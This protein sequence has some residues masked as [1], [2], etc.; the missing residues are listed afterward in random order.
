MHIPASSRHFFGSGKK[1]SFTPPPS[2]HTLWISDFKG[3]RIYA[4]N[5]AGE[6]VWE[7]NMAA[8]P[9]PLRSYNV[10]V[11]YVTV[12]PNGN[13]VAADGEGMM[14]QEIDRRT[15]KLVWQYGVRQR[16]GFQKGFLHQPDKAYKIGAHEVLI[17]DG[18]NRRVIIVDQRTNEIV[19]QYGVTLKMSNKPGYL[20]G[21]T[22]AVPVVLEPWGTPLR[23]PQK[24]H[25]GILITDTL[26]KKLLLVDRQTKKIVWEFHK[27]DAR[28]L[29]HAAPTWEGTIVVE[30]RQRGE[31]FEVNR[32]GQIIRTIHKLGDGKPLHYPSDVLRLGNGN[33]LI[34]EMGRG[35]I[36][37]VNP[38]TLE[39]VWQFGLGKPRRSARTGLATTIAIDQREIKKEAP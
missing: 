19:W 30:D 3:N 7:Q 27:P 17:N 23:D 5:R 2:F 25:Y 34:A 33:Y 24:Q 20:R 13:L 39:I 31:V 38:Q 9:L 28:W 16:Q 36:V 12:A 6:V 11:E 18:N 35:R 26:E 21:N 29:Q 32:A 37:E 4:V 15:H 22:H 1:L 8:P 10:H 14:V